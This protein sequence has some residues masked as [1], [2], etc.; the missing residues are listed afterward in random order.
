MTRPRKPIDKDELEKLAMMQCTTEEIAYWFNVS[1]DTIERRFAASL[2]KG[3]AIGK[4]S[5][6]RQLFAEVQK[7]NLG[8]MVWWGKNFAGMSDKIEQKQDIKQ[9]VKTDIVIEWPDDNVNQN[10]KKDSSTE[11][12]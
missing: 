2:K 9:T 1:P 10:A 7:G 11:K 8:A 4:M 5:M 6:K 3:R 12:V